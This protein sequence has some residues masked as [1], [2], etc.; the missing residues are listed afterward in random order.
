MAMVSWVGNASAT[1]SSR[2]Y[3][4]GE[5]PPGITY[6]ADQVI[7]LDEGPLLAP[8]YI[9]GRFLCLESRPGLALF[10]SFTKH[11]DQLVF[12]KLV[13]SVTFSGNCPPGL[14]AGSVI[15]PDLRDPLT[16]KAVFHRN[17][18]TVVTAESWSLPQT[19]NKN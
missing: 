18:L 4:A 15:A 14:H 9:T 7:G 8:S 11:G 10:S 19:Q 1:D 3:P 5:F 17:D 12:G 6:A 16:I 13:L 2:L